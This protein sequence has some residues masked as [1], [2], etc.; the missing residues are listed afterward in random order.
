VVWGLVARRA[1]QSV[2]RGTRWTL[3]IIAVALLLSG[4]RA[5]SYHRRAVPAF[6]RVRA[7]R[8]LVKLPATM[9]QPPEVSAADHTIIFFFPGKQPSVSSH[10]YPRPERGDRVLRAVGCWRWSAV[11]RQPSR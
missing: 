11:S 10:D 8:R 2:R 4:A 9:A 3:S 5:W 6:G 7:A 1:Q